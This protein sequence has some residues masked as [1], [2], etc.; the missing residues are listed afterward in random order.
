M[1]VTLAEYPCRVHL[2][3]GRE[4]APVWLVAGNLPEDGAGPYP[5]NVW[6]WSSITR[7]PYQWLVSRCEPE[8]LSPGVW[9]LHLEGVEGGAFDGQDV[10][11]S[12]APGSS[13]C[14]DPMK[15]FRP[16]GVTHRRARR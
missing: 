1:A 14:G 5:T 2:P 7:S 3:N 11:I 16:P 9:R 10:T 12:R 15:A 13:C 6:R 4:V 8:Q